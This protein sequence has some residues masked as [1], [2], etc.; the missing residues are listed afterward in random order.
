MHAETGDTLRE[1]FRRFFDERGF[2]VFA[3]YPNGL[4]EPS[5]AGVNS[6]TFRG[7]N[8]L[9][10]WPAKLAQI[11]RPNCRRLLVWHTPFLEPRLYR[12]EFCSPS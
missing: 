12:L 4:K 5:N 2:D 6:D 1:T 7:R 9:G 8:F 11:S 10:R 3:I